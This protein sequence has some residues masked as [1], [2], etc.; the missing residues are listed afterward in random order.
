MERAGTSNK[1]VHIRRLPYKLSSL[2]IDRGRGLDKDDD[3]TQAAQTPD[4][5][6]AAILA[7]GAASRARADEFLQSQAALAREQ[8]EL[9]RLQADDLRREDAVRHWSLRVRH[10][11]DVMKLAFELAVAVIVVALATSIGG[12]I[13]AASHD[14]GLVIEAF[15]VPPDLVSRGLT[16]QVIAAQLQDKLTAMQN[17]TK[18]GRPA[19]SY[20]DNWGN[21]IKV[22]I[23]DTGVSIGEAYRYLAG[24]LGNETHISGEVYRTPSGIAVTARAGLAG[25]TTVSGADSDFDALI[26]KTAEKIYEQTQPYRYAVYLQDVDPGHDAQSRAVLDRLVDTGSPRDRAWAYIALGNLEVSANAF[27]KAI[28]DDTAAMALE[29]SLVLADSDIDSFQS[30]FGHDEAS[31]AAARNAVRLF[32]SG[33]AIDISDAAH[34]Q[35]FAQ[36]KASVAF[37]ENNFQA[38]LRVFSDH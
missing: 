23:P 10:V 12:A 35:I 31:L 6:A 9:T 34:D 5:S 36:E 15:S 25:S 2:R 17:A 32:E 24:W 27:D 1:T 37:A 22:E 18:S 7:L 21:D 4:M 26:Q 20:S 38:A 13:W 16:G 33:D 3:N 8:A 19:A 30:T 28:R 29:P 11:S 14:N